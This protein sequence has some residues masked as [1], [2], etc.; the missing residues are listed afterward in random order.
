VQTLHSDVKAVIEQPQ[1]RTPFV[2]LWDLELQPRT[3]SLPP[4]VFRMTSQPAQ[5]Q[6]W[7]PSGG[8]ALTFYPFPFSQSEIQQSSEGN[9]PSLDLSVD[10]TTRVL[11]QYLHAGQGF[12]GNR[13]T[14]YLGVATSLPTTPVA[15]NTAFQT[16]D[17]R[18]ASAIATEQ[19]ITITIR[20]PGLWNIN[21]PSARF[22]AL[23]CR[24][25][26]G[27]PECGYPI[28]ATA[29]FTACDKL[30]PSCIARGND[31]RARHLPVLHPRRFGGF[32]GIPVQRTG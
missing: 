17:F 13:I 30:L 21:V 5:H 29:G 2:W 12:E 16:F 27:G 31:E 24:W 26:F 6:F 20:D 10:N 4:V 19:A 18:V 9:L 14:C 28:T 32:P 1:G 25:E 11:M 3:V 23:R 15:A 8:G 22:V 7:P